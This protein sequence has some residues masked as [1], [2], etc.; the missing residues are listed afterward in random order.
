MKKITNKQE[1]LDAVSEDGM[2]LEECSYELRNERKGL[3]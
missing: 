3:D 2:K 1:A